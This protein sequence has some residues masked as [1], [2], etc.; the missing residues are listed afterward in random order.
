M[1]AFP[2]SVKRF[3]LIAACVTLGWSQLSGAT[4]VQLSLA[5]MIGQST[6]IEHAKVAGAWAAFS[7]PA[8]F[9][10]YKLQVSERWKG[11]AVTEIVVFGGVANGVRQVYSG[12]PQLNA[13]ED[14]VFFLWTNKEGMTHIVGMTQGLFAVAR[15]GGA[16]PGLTRSASQ[17]RMLDATTGRDVKDRT[18]TMKLSD[19]RAR[20]SGA[21]AAAKAVR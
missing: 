10:H 19:L 4:L 7:G 21:L 15:D 5:D 6:T 20:V 3:P 18:L 12:T 14:Y 1:R 11:T 8:I 13:G 9:T 17:E 16:D 2:R